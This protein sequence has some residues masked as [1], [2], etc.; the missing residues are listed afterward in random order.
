MN[1]MQ[2]FARP[3]RRGV[4]ALLLIALLQGCGGPA[5]IPGGG[6]GAGPDATPP[7]VP[8]ALTATAQ[9]PASIQLTWQPS[10][11]A[12]TGV[13]GYRVF[14]DGGATAVAT[15]TTPSWLDT[16]LTANTTYS[17]TVRAFDGAAPA[18]ESG[19]SAAA[20]ATTPATPVPGV[21]G[22]D[23]R[24]SNTACLAGE[25]PSSSVSL[26]LD[27][28]FA[29]LGAFSSPVLMLQ[30]PASTA[31]WYV[32]QK[33]GI[34]FVFDNQPNATTRREFINLTTQIT[35]SASDERGLLGMAFHP[36]YPTNPRVYAS[37]TATASGQLV[38][39][40][41][42]FQTRD[43]GQTLD[44]TSGQTIL[45]VNQPESNHNGGQIAFGPDGYLYIG[46]GDGGGGGDGHGSIGNG[47]RLST[48]LGKMLRID[49]NSTTAGG[50]R[51]AIPATNPFQ[52]P[53]CNNDTGA[54]TT[55]CPE[56][57]A[58]GFRN[59]WRWSFDRVSGELWV[60]DVGQGAWEEVDRVVLGGNYGWRCR[61][62][63]HAFN[64][65][66]GPN[67]G[68][69]IDPIAEYDHQ[70]GVSI[71]GGHVYRGSAIPALAGRYLFGDFGSG[72]IWHVARDATPT[73][74]FTT[75]FN[76]GLSISSF[77]QDAAGEIYVVNFG[78][79]LHRLRAGAAGGR[80]IP[81]QLSA[82]GCVSA[83]NATQPS[84][85]LI[86]Y[87]P[88][89][90]F[91]S[92]GAVKSRYLALPDG[93]RIAIGAD[94][95]FDFPNG[96]VLVKNFRIGTQPVE[97]RLFMRH[98][99]GEWA[100]YTYEWN[101]QGTDATRVIGGKTVQ[102]AGQSWL[103]PSEAQCLVCHT[104]AAGR[105]LGLEQSQLNG[106]LTYAATGR[107][108]NQLDTLNAIS[109]LTPAL[110]LPAA[111]LPAMPDPFGTAGTLAQRAR[112]YLHTNCSNCHRPGGGTPV[113]MDLRY[114]TP[115]ASTNACE[116]VPARSL[117]IA[118]ARL[119]A[120]GG[121]DPA[122]RSL[123]VARPSRTDADAMPPLLPRTADAAGV[124]LLAS[125]VNSLASC[126]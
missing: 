71:T 82:T 48:L 11:D 43:G 54:F 70:Q 125:W 76:S 86:P 58:Y 108:A 89:A 91:W 74:Q 109:T 83:T 16:G 39:R 112:A 33:T 104:A 12:G 10:T 116:V 85:G 45:Q 73:Q 107:T 49:V 44:A 124:A 114:G 56:I 105:S 65:A 88:N 24:P 41:V 101:A 80:V 21:S 64:G 120:V 84:A 7:S 66:C 69:S 100:G 121:T 3:A 6:G 95:D 102:V 99:N 111:Q 38:S 47:Q 98:G 81:A 75:G 1:G 122:A 103:F 117:G 2:G 15:V 31:R 34:V 5:T 8:A 27:Q 97:T 26:A 61:E 51:Y 40:I 53:V 17:Y 92:D 14:R 55:N 94:G 62:G 19:G 67:A 4:S 28:V 118:N 9:S 13:A 87:A 113:N 96:S 90:P 50:T 37:F 63:A 18:N 20:S 32:V 36:D 126:N 52:G 59:P 25:A 23:S 78:G 68:S 93:Q 110:T 57:Y 42:E 79:T 115:L 22:L 77:A 123:L 72:R 30:E 60:G 106:S 35:G 29:G 46:L 119:I